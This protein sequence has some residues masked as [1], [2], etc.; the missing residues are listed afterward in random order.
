MKLF[1]RI[2]NFSAGVAVSES[3]G[4]PGSGKQ[5]RVITQQ[6]SSKGSGSHQA[7]GASLAVFLRAVYIGYE[8]SGLFV[9]PAAGS[10]QSG[11]I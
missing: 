6:Y 4:T 5:P 3:A 11:L 1:K 10:H 9:W 8:H 2:K 7:I